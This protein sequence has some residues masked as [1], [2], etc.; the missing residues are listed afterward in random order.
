MHLVNKEGLLLLA[1]TALRAVHRD[2]TDETCAGS[3]SASHDPL[4]P[5]ASRHFT[6]LPHRVRIFLSPPSSIPSSPPRLAHSTS[7]Q[8]GSAKYTAREEV[9]LEQKCSNS[10]RKHQCFSL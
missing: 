9:P 10:R 5:E 6:F 2:Q 8:G 4:P 1:R 7:N 3:V